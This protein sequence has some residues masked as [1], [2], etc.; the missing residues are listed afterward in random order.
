MC[1]FSFIH[2]EE[3]ASMAE[4]ACDKDSFAGKAI[5]ICT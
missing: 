5:T 3:F 2:L 1:P 4:I